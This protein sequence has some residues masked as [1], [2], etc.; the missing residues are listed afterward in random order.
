MCNILDVSSGEYI[1][2]DRLGVLV[3]TLCFVLTLGLQRTGIGSD[4]M[5]K[6]ISS[7]TDIPE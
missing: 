1:C 7:L 5:I 6:K 4:D 2:R 3:L